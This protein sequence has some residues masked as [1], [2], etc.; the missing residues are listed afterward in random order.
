MRRGFRIIAAAMIMISLTA[1]S[2]AAQKNQRDLEGIWTNGTITPLERPREFSE[3]EFLT[4]EEAAQ[5]EKQVRERNHGDRRDANSDAD[6]A[7]G[8]NDF[9]WDRGTKVV[10]SRRT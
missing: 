7:T 4:P 9:W 2:A 8:Y 5:Y 10:S 1:I 3:K 6:L